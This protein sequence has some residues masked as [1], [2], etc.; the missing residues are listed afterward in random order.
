MNET[1][2]LDEDNESVN[3]TASTISSLSESIITQKSENG[4]NVAGKLTSSDSVSKVTGAS[5][6]RVT[7]GG[8]STLVLG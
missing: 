7:G 1:T 6:K 3:E 5:K 4:A 8:A 2:K